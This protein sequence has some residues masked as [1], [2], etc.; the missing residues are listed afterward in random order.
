MS[1]LGLSVLVNKLHQGAPIGK[2]Y[3]EKLI[4][5]E[6]NDEIQIFSL[7]SRNTQLINAE[8]WIAF[9]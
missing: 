2:C 5:F 8:L 4:Q 6:K 3:E 9:Y 1:T 7:L